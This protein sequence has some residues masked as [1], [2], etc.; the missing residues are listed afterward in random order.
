MTILVPGID[1]VGVDLLTT[2]YH[3]AT[4]ASKLNFDVALLCG[5]SRLPV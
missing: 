1:E 3:D 2:F 4:I 5:F